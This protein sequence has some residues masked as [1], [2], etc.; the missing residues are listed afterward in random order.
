MT[1][2]YLNPNSHS[3][4]IE[5]IILRIP[6]QSMWYQQSLHIVERIAV[7]YC[8][9]LQ[10]TSFAFFFIYARTQ[11]S[12]KRMDLE[13]WER[14]VA[15][16]TCHERTPPLDQSVLYKSSRVKKEYIFHT[17]R[18]YLIVRA[19]CN[20]L[21]EL[22]MQHVKRLRLQ[23]CALLSATACVFNAT[24]GES[25]FFTNHEKQARVKARIAVLG[26]FFLFCYFFN[27]GKC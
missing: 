24:Q 20:A 12:N 6:A 8:Y 11:E 21:Y 2:C 15:V 27:K 17:Q 16:W 19:L 10:E 18:A 23:T 9:G 7:C 1:F 13:S 26:C 5:V 4:L 25:C 22:I 14:Q 3:F